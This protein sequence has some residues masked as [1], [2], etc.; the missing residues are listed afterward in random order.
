MRGANMSA[1]GVFSFA[2]G[3]TISFTKEARYEMCAVLSSDNVGRSSDFKMCGRSNDAASDSC[4]LSN[5][6]P[7]REAC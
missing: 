7:V 2:R 1:A 5:Y 6:A 3:A 4:S